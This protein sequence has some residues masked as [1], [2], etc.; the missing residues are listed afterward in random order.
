MS[1]FLLVVT[2]LFSFATFIVLWMTQ[3]EDSSGISQPSASMEY[4]ESSQSAE[5]DEESGEA[6]IGGP[7]TLTD[8][9]GRIRT[10]LDFRGKVMIVFFGFT[11]CPDICPVTVA[12]LSSLMELL[13][14]KAAQVVPIFITVDPTRDTPEVMKAYL[15]N[16]DSRIVA[17]TGNTK[18]IKE[19]AD[20][21]KAYFAKSAKKADDSG[22]PAVPDSQTIEGHAAH[23]A[24]GEHGAARSEADYLMDHSGYIYVMDQEGKYVKH[25]PYNVSEQELVDELKPFLK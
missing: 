21:Y 16:F 8:Q 5:K 6:D 7:F 10:D 4:A 17:L 20:N 11:N 23:G 9:M 2:V 14:D 19:V 22:I 3:G 25:F 12:T 15:Q 18:S 13:G 1:K 24:H